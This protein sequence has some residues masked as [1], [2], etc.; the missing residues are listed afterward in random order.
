MYRATAGSEMT[1]NQFDTDTIIWQ[2]NVVTHELDAFSELE[3]TDYNNRSVR[4]YRD[5]P[6]SLDELFRETAE[7]NP[8]QDF[9]V[10]PESDTRRTYREVEQRV[11]RLAAG[12]SNESLL[13]NGRIALVCDNRL[14][15]V[16]VILAG[17]RLGIV[18]IP[19]NTRHSPR[20][21]GYMLK[22]S[23]PDVVVAEKPHL[24]KIKKSNYELSQERTF[25]IGSSD[26]VRSYEELA[27]TGTVNTVSLTA[28]DPCMI[29][30]T[31][32]TTGRPKGVPTDNFHCMNAVLNNI[33]IHGLTE[34][35]TVLIPTPLF[36]VTGL[37]CGLFTTMAVAGTGVILESYSPELFVETIEKETITYCMGVPMNII[38][39]AE[40]I[41]TLEYDI[42]SFEKFAYGGAPMPSDAIPRIRE[43]F[44]D[45]DL[46]HSY[47][48][49]EN[50]AGI[51]AMIPDS[52]ID[53]RPE[54]VGLPTPVTK[55]TVVDEDRN[56]LPPGEV[57]ELSMYAPFVVERYLNLPQKSIEEFED[58]WHY[59]GDLGVIGKDGFIE[60]KGRKGNMIIRGGENIYP[61]EIEEVF[62]AND[63]V[64]EAGVAAFPDDVL[65]ERVL[66]AVVPKE[67]ERLT[68]EGLLKM[69][70]ENLAEY[71]IPDLFRI[72]DELPRNA[73]G[74]V[75]R[76]E[77][78][79]DPLQFGIKAGE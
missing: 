21:L 76:D 37:V 25:V 68:E 32:G 55:F 33:H 59:T 4:A 17:A 63:R 67:G 11:N 70:M 65:G 75:E 16:E 1:V 26:V 23:D 51:A 49:T 61:V 18:T 38:L 36:H 73:N 22:D 77:L 50:L 54:S 45:T 9:I 74:K 34:G 48:K 71:K 42:S 7:A 57:G 66:A 43:A 56:R 27:E 78:I 62:L 29:L 46:Y 14:E 12:I 44:P 28:S 24:E 40:K 35:A 19:L 72:V 30:Y 47:G 53:E 5:R 64:L 52:Y 41:D 3:I 15:F 69:C 60:L 58:G 2:D 20:E 8:D 6:K 10:L 13:E 39:A 79:L 31:S